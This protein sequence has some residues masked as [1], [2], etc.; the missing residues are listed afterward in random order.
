MPGD[1]DRSQLESARADVFLA[2]GTSLVVYPAA[3][4]THE[5]K[6]RGAFA[7]EINPAAT[8]ASRVVDLALEQPAVDALD[9]LDRL[10][11]HR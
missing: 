6:R 3:G 5:A 7:V 11:K 4:L 8:D 1:L 10:L 9:A 2:I